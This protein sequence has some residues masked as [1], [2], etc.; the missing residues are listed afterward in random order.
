MGKTNSFLKGQALMM[1]TQSQLTISSYML[2]TMG[3]GKQSTALMVPNVNAK[4]TPSMMEFNGTV[5]SVGWC[6]PSVRNA[7]ILQ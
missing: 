3:T 4:A 2:M 6:L 1:G 5:R 7:N